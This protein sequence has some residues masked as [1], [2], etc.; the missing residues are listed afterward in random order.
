M[1]AL[2]IRVAV[3]ATLIAVGSRATPMNAQT[4]TNNLPESSVGGLESDKTT[5]YVDNRNFRD[6]HVYAVTMTGRRR[7]LG[8][9]NGVSTREFELPPSLFEGGKEFQI[10]VYP[11]GIPSRFNYIRAEGS[12]IK[13]RPIAVT[14]GARIMLF[15]SSNINESTVAVVQG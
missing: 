15:L 6:Q 1:L 8:I 4:R 12:G 9:V 13:T 14:A 7:L 3:I 5:L 11:L 10:K 2:R